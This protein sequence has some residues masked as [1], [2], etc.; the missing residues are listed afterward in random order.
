MGVKTTPPG[1][2]ITVDGKPVGKSPVTTEV[3]SGGPPVVVKA[4]VGDKEV[5]KT[6]QR[7]GTNWG[8]VGAGAGAGVGTFCAGWVCSFALGFT[9]LAVA[10]IP[11]GCI[12][13]A[14]L[15]G[16]PVGAYFMWGGKP[17]DQVTI[18]IAGAPSTLPPPPPPAP[19]E[20]VPPSDGSSTPPPEPLP[21]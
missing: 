17:P 18:D 13:C 5:S 2:D 19:T 12:G 7:D 3:P 6:V 1:A 9:P 16:M 10:G 11:I 21:Y 4:K 8:A 20:P 15:V 14:S